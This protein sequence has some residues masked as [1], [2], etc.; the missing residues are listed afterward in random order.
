MVEYVVKHILSLV[1]V[2]SLPGLVITT[3]VCKLL[4]QAG[5]SGRYEVGIGAVSCGLFPAY[6]IFQATGFE[7]EL[8]KLAFGSLDM[9]LLCLVF[10]AA[11]GALSH[12]MWHDY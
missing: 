2:Y 3:L 10:G 6:G 8:K 1:F 11:F 7:R 9:L 4:G 12:W 5:P